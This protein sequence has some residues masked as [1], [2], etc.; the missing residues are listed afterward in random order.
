[1]GKSLDHESRAMLVNF[2]L[3]P[4]FG[5]LLHDRPGW[6]RAARRRMATT[7]ARARDYDEPVE[8]GTDGATLC[9]RGH[10]HCLRQSC[11]TRHESASR[12]AP[13]SQ[14]SCDAGSGGDGITRCIAGSGGDGIARRIAGSGGDGI[15]RRIAVAGRN[16]RHSTVSGTFPYRGPVRR[17][18]DG[19]DSRDHRRDR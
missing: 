10:H 11:A 7:D 6:Y 1:L 3:T 12:N 15:A 16:Q 19:R 17:C 5:D 9:A 8:T 2:A 18:L 4:G 14:S 13:G